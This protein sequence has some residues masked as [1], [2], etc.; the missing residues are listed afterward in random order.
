[1]SGWVFW[2]FWQSVALISENLK[3]C[4]LYKG[5]ILC[6]FYNFSLCLVCED[7]Q[8]CDEHSIY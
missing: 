8:N 2:Q 3:G 7:L 1:M 6:M 5:K 4:W